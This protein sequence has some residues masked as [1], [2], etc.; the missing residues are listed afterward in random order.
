MPLAETAKNQNIKYNFQEDD[1]RKELEL[2]LIKEY[3]FLNSIGLL[4]GYILS[5]LR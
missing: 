4:F 5:K 1:N 2:H 3:T